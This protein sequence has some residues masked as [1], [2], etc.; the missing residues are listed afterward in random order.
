MK[1]EGEG[2]KLFRSRNIICF[3]FCQIPDQAN[4]MSVRLF[5]MVGG[6]S[7]EG[8]KRPFE[9]I[10]TQFLWSFLFLT[11]IQNLAYRAIM[12]GDSFEGLYRI[13]PKGYFHLTGNNFSNN[14][15]FVTYIFNN[16]I[17]SSFFCRPDWWQQKIIINETSSRE[18]TRNYQA[19]K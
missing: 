13:W 12:P 8:E 14:D 7:Q 15:Y 2:S 16:A 18:K 17:S 1:C 10:L 5:A 11:T 19:K 4:G 3:S 9:N 6:E